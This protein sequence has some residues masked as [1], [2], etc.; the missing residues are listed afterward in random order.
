MTEVAVP[1]TL[2]QYLFELKQKGLID[3][4]LSRLLDAV[5]NLS[6]EI[7]EKVTL[8]A[9]GGVLGLAGTE[10]V[11]GEDQKKLDVLSNE[12]FVKGV[13]WTGSLAGMA[14]EE[15]DHALPVSKE[16]PR[17]KYLI[18]FDPLDGSSNIDINA[19][20]GTIFSIS[21]APEGEITDESFLIPGREQVAAGYVMY[22]PQTIMTFSVGKGV[23]MFTFNPATGQYLLTNEKVSVPVS[24]AEFA[25]NMSNL[26][27]WATPVRNYVR[28]LLKGADGP[29]G[30]NYNMRWVAAMVAEVH[31]VL[32]R[33]GIFMYPWD[34]RQPERPGKLRLLYEANPMAFLSEQAGAQ[35]TN[36]TQRI[37]DLQPEKLHQRVAVFL[38]AKEEV[39]R[40]KQY[41]EKAK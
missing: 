27:H 13:Q 21:K 12:I 29:I 20:I 16:Y 23:V 3:H 22:S 32:T 25:I 31:R 33:G 34:N 39:E 30:K 9:L 26:R 7:R 5:A 24:T 35:A 28:D 40:V 17:G 38:G 15:M 6:K 1:V 19:P 18:A 11:Q 37:L 2:N 4:Q 10:N 8:G 14:S 36:G 41:V